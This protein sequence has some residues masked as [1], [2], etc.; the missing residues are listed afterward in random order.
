[1]TNDEQYGKLR[2]KAHRKKKV[3][4]WT[5]YSPF[6]D[7]AARIAGYVATI[8]LRNGYSE[9]LHFVALSK[10]FSPIQ[11]SDIKRLRKKVEEAFRLCDMSARAISWEDWIE[12]EMT[13]E[14]N[15]AEE[16]GVGLIVQWKFLK[17]G[18]HPE[19]GEAFTIHHSNGV[20]VP[21]PKPKRAG[22]N[23]QPKGDKWHLGSRTES[24]QFSYIP[25]TPDNVAA[26]E[27]LAQRIAGARARLRD[28]LNQDNAPKSLASVGLLRLE[29]P[30]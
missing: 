3:D 21:F 4:V 28:L 16:H 29:G 19:S 5:F 18:I 14:C 7:E 26:L 24:S 15:F 10:H 9:G 23:D 30:K 6:A 25:A 13:E 17:R 11:D 20:V 12:I 22:E 1:M 8:E 2:E 27:S